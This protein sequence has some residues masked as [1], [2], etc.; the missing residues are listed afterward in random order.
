MERVAYERLRWRC[1]RR[2]LLEV[3]ITLG[4]FLDEVFG[5]LSEDEQQAFAE[6]ADRDD[7]ELWHLISGQEECEDTRLAP[8]VRMLRNVSDKEKSPV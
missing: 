8:I 1:I 7:L 6:L 2:G 5:G 4:R 3:D